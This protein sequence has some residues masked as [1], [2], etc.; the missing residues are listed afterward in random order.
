MMKNKI[1][2]LLSVLLFIATGFTLAGCGKKADNIASDRSGEWG[3]YFA[4]FEAV[5]TE[6]K[7]TTR[8]LCIDRGDANLGNYEKL[9][10]LLDEYCKGK[11]IQLLEGDRDTLRQEKRLTSDG[12]F[13]D[14]YLVSFAEIVWSK[15]RDT[16]TVTVALSDFSIVDGTNPGGTVTV[17]KGDGRWQAQICPDGSTQK[18]PEGAYLAVFEYCIQNAGMSGQRDCLAVATNG[19]EREVKDKV[20]E[21]LKALAATQGYTCRK[22]TWEQLVQDGLVSEAGEFLT[23]YHLSYSDIEWQASDLAIMTCRIMQS[24]TQVFFRRFTVLWEGERWVATST[25]SQLS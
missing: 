10:R 1:S 23:G 19:I 16:L 6:M 5:S 25:Q 13:T 24:E 14:G 12:E 8:F 3:A 17:T 22:A 11:K 18:G 15:G 20:F 7:P 4:A 9:Y 2:L 21:G